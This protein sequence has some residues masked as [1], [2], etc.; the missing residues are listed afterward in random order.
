MSMKVSTYLNAFTDITF[1][2]QTLAKRN[3]YVPKQH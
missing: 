3:D 2:N 1:N